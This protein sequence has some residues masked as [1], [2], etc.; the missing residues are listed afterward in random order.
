MQIV[1]AG[2]DRLLAIER[3]GRLSF[4]GYGI[5]FLIALSCIGT[6]VYPFL[7]AR[8]IINVDCIFKGITGL[9]CPTCGYSAAIGCLIG[10]D[11]THSFLHNPG[12]ILWVALQITLVFIGI[13][14]ILSGRQAVIPARLVIPLV[15]LI[16]AT[17][18]SK[19]I[20]GSEYY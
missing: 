6:L 2:L 3:N 13:K 9:P 12:W 1:E 5:N 10:G 4:T 11:I 20:I 8:G 17:W 18:A 19:F 16:L 7:D 14:S 15:I